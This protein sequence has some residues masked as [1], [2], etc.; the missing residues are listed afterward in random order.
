M[1]RY[2]I[3]SDIHSN[4]EALDAVLVASSKQKCDDV[5]VLGD[6]VG[7]GADPN[8]VVMRIRELNPKAVIRGNHDKV[9]AGL[10]TPDDFNAMARTAALW[11]QQALSRDVLAYLQALP[12]GPALIAD[13]LG[14]CHGS[15]IDEDMYIVADL[16]A[17]R[18]LECTRLPLCMFG[19]T[20]V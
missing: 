15:P 9:A 6:L 1:S 18:S 8:A 12:Q 7:Y 13:D 5:I 16:D 10:E 4:L 11:T 19:H 20:H 3:L 17:V 2:L 14:I